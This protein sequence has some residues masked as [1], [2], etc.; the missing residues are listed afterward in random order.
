[1]KKW[2]IYGG[3]K[4]PT[5]LQAYV[6][7]TLD[8]MIIVCGRPDHICHGAAPG[9]DTMAGKWAIERGFE[10]GKSLFVFPA[11]WKKLGP[12]AGPVRNKK[13]LLEFEPTL[14]VAFPGHIGTANMI[15]IA[16]EAG[17][18]VMNMPAHHEV[19]Y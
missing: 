9:I 11:D 14:I 18:K 8:K 12:K 10:I 13:M 17:V 5:H 15:Q 6:S 4:A 3:H 1:M 2:L 19:G 7:E 16:K